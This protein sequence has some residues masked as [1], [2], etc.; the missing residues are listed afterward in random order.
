MLLL[1]VGV[2]F[3]LLV[4]VLPGCPLY[5]TL[6]KDSCYTIPQIPQSWTSAMA[7]CMAHGAHLAEITSSEENHFVL[8]LVKQNHP[9]EVELWIGGTD[10][11]SEGHWV[12]THSGTLL[13]YQNWDVNE[14]NSYSDGE[15]CL[16][17]RTNGKWNDGHCNVTL[18]GICEISA[19]TE[20]GVGK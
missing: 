3:T 20:P 15:Q 18:H 2:S 11:V 1:L 5:W 13:G 16:T 14:P 8:Q 9:S 12:W 17:F 19:L 10:A 4:G 6:H 7:F